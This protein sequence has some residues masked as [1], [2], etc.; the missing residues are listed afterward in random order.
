VMTNVETSF[1]Y[2]LDIFE[3]RWP[4]AEKIIRTKPGI[5]ECYVDEVMDGVDD[6]GDNAGV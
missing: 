2:A 1:Q 4:E 6:G 5:W 3:G